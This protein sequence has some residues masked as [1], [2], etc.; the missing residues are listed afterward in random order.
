MCRAFGPVKTIC[1]IYGTFALVC[2]HW[3]GLGWYVSGFWPCEN[4]L[5][6]P[7]ELCSSLRALVRPRLVC[8][9]FLAL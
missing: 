6:N 1:T 7:W 2:E 8:V 4:Y 5:H 9:G 3:F